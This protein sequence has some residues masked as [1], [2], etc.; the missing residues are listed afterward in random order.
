MSR[1]QIIYF[2]AVAKN[3]NFTEAARQLYVAQSALSKQ[4]QALETELDLQLF[5]RTSRSVT[6]TPAGKVLFRELEKY[7]EWLTRSIALARQASDAKTGSLSVGILYGINIS[8]PEI[9]KFPDFSEAFPH[10]Q[11]D[12]KRLSFQDVEEELHKKKLD[13]TIIFSFL[14]PN[15]PSVSTY[16]LQSGEDFVAISRSSPLGLLKQV[17]AEDL[18]QN[19]LVTISPEISRQANINSLHYLRGAGVVPTKIKYV[20]TIEDIMLSIEYGLGYGVISRATRLF[21]EKSIRIIDIYSDAPYR[22]STDIVA[23]WN[24][25][26]VNPAIMHYINFVDT[27]K[28]ERSLVMD[29]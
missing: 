25:D 23:L 16:V 18:N 21:F 6:L 17:A 11:I 2:L 27:L 24:R 29:A 4:I 3:L 28:A 8:N 1:T 7:D 20:N 14:V 26:T 15:I 5:E 22:P 9:T 12:M 19:T 10:I 13:L